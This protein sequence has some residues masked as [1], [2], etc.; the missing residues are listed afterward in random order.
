MVNRLKFQVISAALLAASAML[1][2]WAIVTL[3]RLGSFEAAAH[4]VFS[5]DPSTDTSFGVVRL[6]YLAGPFCS[7]GFGV[8]CAILGTLLV[9]RSYGWASIAAITC[10]APIVVL[11][12]LGYFLGGRP[13][14]SATG[15]GPVKSAA[16]R[17]MSQIDHLT[18]WRF[19]GGYHLVSVGLGVAVI[20]LLAGMVTLLVWPAATRGS[21]GAHALRG[22]GGMA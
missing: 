17:D 1:G 5:Q 3:L 7:L 20:G 2:A 16:I 6:E 4:S 22:E 14:I 21:E 10:S 12:V 18:Q 11:V 9:R 8:V 15:T 19:S 13:Y